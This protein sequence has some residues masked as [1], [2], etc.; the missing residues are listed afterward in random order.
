LIV[1]LVEHK[2]PKTIEFLKI[3]TEY[4]DEEIKEDAIE[5]LEKLDLKDYG[6]K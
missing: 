5:E 3:L 1:L 6:I 4:P 2:H